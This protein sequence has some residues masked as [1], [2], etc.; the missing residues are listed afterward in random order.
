MNMIRATGKRIAQAGLVCGALLSGA[1][2]AQLDLQSLGASLLGGGQQQ[3][4]AAPAQGAAAP[5]QGAVAQLLQ[6]Y[7]GANQQVLTGQSSL[8]S[9]MGL[10]GAA[11]QAQQAA[12]LLGSGGNALTP[13]ALSQMGGAQQSVSQAL[14]QAFASGGGTHGPVDKQAFSNGLASLGQ[15]LTQYSQLQSGLGGLGSTSPAA[16]LQAG[17]NPQNMQAASYIAQSTPGQL[18]S[19]ATTLSQAVQFATSQGI[20][21][22]SVASSA[23]KL[24]P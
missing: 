16:L 15:G 3:A 18:Q 17:L 13:A 6:A 7:V 22:P 21:V 20:S 24:L 12:S 5:A 23:L 1:A 8:A 2:H 10:T 14:G 11:G 4:A 9:A 19:L